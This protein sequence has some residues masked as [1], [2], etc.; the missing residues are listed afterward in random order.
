[1][2]LEKHHFLWGETG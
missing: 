2:S 1:M